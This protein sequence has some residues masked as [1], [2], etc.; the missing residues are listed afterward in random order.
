MPEYKSKT[1]LITGAGNGIGREIAIRFAAEGAHVISLDV[2]AAANDHTASSIRRNG[3]RCDALQGD[4]SNEE[5]VQR[6]FRY[7]GHVDV[8]INNAAVW[9]K[10]GFLHELTEQDWDRIV[11]VTLKS[12]FLCSREAIRLMAP[13]RS[14]CIIN[15]GSVNALSG[16]HLAAYSAAKGGVLAL[17]RVLVQQYGHYGIRI[18]SICPGTI[19]TESSKAMYDA[20]PTLGAELKNLYPSGDFGTPADIA[21]CALFLASEAARFI[22]G[23]TV[24]VDGGATAVHRL[25]SAMASF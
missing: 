8:L 11:A 13:R 9:S 22:N 12:V 21:D 6:A 25:P 19:L 17:T 2:D 14:G 24:V 15:I 23:S 4:A 5:D 20:V 10:D 16:F 1:L 3:G 7:A 18:N